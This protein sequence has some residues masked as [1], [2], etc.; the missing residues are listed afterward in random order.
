[1]NRRSPRMIREIYSDI[2]S[3]YQNDTKSLGKQ[4]VFLNYIK[5]VISFN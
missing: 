2:E 1:M 5:S 4:I 3:T